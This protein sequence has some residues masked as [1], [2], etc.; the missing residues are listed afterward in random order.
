VARTSSGTLRKVEVTKL[1]FSLACEVK[2]ITVVSP[3]VAILGG[4]RISCKSAEAKPL[5][6]YPGLKRLGLH[7]NPKVGHQRLIDGSPLNISCGIHIRIAGITTFLALKTGL[8][9][10]ICAFGMPTLAAFL[11]G[12]TWVD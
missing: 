2:V 1:G 4:L 3:A 5:V 6:D 10:P 11:T 8:R 7:L 9:N 12:V